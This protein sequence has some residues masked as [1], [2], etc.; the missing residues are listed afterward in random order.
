MTEQQ[1]MKVLIAE[2]ERDIRET[3]ADILRDEDFEVF[4][5]QNGKVGFE[6]FKEKK[7]HVIVSDIMMPE[8]DG[9][10]FLKLVRETKD[11]TNN[12]PFLFLSA[13]GQKENIIKG[14][15][16]AASDYLVKPIDFEILIAK[17][18]EKA[19]ASMKLAKTHEKGIKN[20]KDQISTT[21]SSEIN[22]HIDIITHALAILK[23]EPYGPFPHRRYLEDI[24]KLYSEA[25][26]LKTT[27]VNS[28]DENVIEN[29]LN[30]DEE[31]FS[32]DSF[33]TQA[34]KNFPEKI[35]SRVKYERPFEAETISK[36][37]MD[38]SVLIDVIKKIIAGVIKFEPDS[39][40][41]SSIIV[42][43]MNRVILIFYIHSKL[44]IEEVKKNLDE[45][46]VKE[47]CSAQSLEFKLSGEVGK[48]NAMIT[49][50]SFRVIH[51]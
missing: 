19:F 41:S 12:V 17:I 35:K 11:K 9:Y 31:I 18:K 23:E 39:S 7:P 24:N 3:I 10:A 8:V 48:L 20:I 40:I 46:K 2:D 22:Y 30:A 44:N 5:A 32:L 28:L 29:R 14:V 38:K 16:L 47:M 27:V 43:N 21:L 25:V 45:E 33:L 42:D 49:F 36:L 4:E 6:I 34:V 50:P 15:S 1:K 26:K 13:L 37:K 51:A